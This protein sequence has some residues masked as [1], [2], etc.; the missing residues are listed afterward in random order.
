MQDQV[1]ETQAAVHSAK[2]DAWEQLAGASGIREN[3]FD[4]LVIQCSLITGV[5][6][7][8][9][10]LKDAASPQYSPVALWPQSGAT[11]ERLAD[12]CEQV[13][14]DREG[15]LVEFHGEDT[16]RSVLT[17]AAGYPIMIDD[18]LMGV[19]ALE[20]RAASSTAFVEVMEQLQWGV[21]GLELMYRRKQVIGDKK[22]ME[23]LQAAVDLLTVVH[24]E[25]TFRTGALALVTEA[26]A[27]L[28]CD[29]VSFGLYRNRR[30]K[31]EAISHSV[32]IS[33]HM[34]LVRNIATAMDE[35]ILQRREI[36]F[37]SPEDQMVVVRE[38]E[39]LARQCGTQH[40]LTLPL[41]HLQK[42]YGALVFERSGKSGFREDEIDFCRGIASLAVPALEEKRKNDQSLPRKI[43]DS[44]GRQVRSL[45]GIHHLAVKL[46]V[47]LLGM[48]IS[49]ACT[50]QGDY[51]ISADSTLEA[52]SR[53]MLVVPF[54]GY[55]KDAFARAGETVRAGEILC[56]M[57]DRDLEL[58][59]LSYLSQQAQFRSQYLEALAE[60]DRSTLRIIESQQEQVDAQLHLVETRILRSHLT[61]PFDGLVLEGDLSQ[62][63]GEPVERGQALFT[64]AP[65][66]SY[67]VALYVDES[68]IAHIRKGE[69]GEL[70]LTALPQK[71][72][73]F[74]VTKITPLTSPRNGQNVFRVEGE[75]V[76]SSPRLRPGMEGVG[77]I[78]IDKRSYA[79][80][81]TRDLL[82]KITL[83]AWT[84]W[85]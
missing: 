31:V 84:W 32:D 55:I 3:S 60:H 26:A 85:G 13:L 22:R 48:T 53:R 52:T 30:S 19:V 7:G 34:N 49:M 46:L 10:V 2:R 27:R 38:H 15:I 51:R 78:F 73:P 71:K 16:S 5:V 72:F 77:K 69:T 75:L 65:M 33:H 79:A 37:P 17:A 28:Q 44:T 61:A 8:I 6:Q 35:A 82:E 39:A 54:D 24:A 57:D 74:S 47:I 63:L 80:I 40:I 62:M 56:T 50:L 42:Y 81:W 67:R 4:W 14:A 70:L 58:E 83:W 66:H 76:E 21:R 41:H 45:L 25:N 20:F 29:R 59:K 12:L 9:V 36:V 1:Q 18:D 68:H 11:P 64:M 43:M 23:R